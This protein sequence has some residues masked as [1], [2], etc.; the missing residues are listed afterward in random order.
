MYWGTQISLFELSRVLLDVHW[1]SVRF[2][3]AGSYPND[4]Q[5]QDRVCDSVRK[6]LYFH[7]HFLVQPHHL[8]L[9]HYILLDRYQ[10]M[11]TTC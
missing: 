10:I 1:F 3:L 9:V 11:Y 8:G 2:I 6:R 7:C 4:V 5:D